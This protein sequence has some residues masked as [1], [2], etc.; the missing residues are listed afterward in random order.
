VEDYTEA[1]TR[2][3]LLSDYWQGL[4]I[5]GS[6]AQIARIRSSKIYWQRNLQARQL[7]IDRDN[8]MPALEGFR[9]AG[10]LSIDIDGNDYWVWEAIDFQPW[11]VICEY[12]SLFGPTAKISIPYNSKFQRVH[13][14][15]SNLYFGCSLNALCHLA[16]KKGYVFVGCNRMGSNAFFVR[17]D[18]SRDFRTL[19]AEEGFVLT[20]SR[21]SR[22]TEGKLDYLNALESMELIASLPVVDVENGTVLKLADLPLWLE[23]PDSA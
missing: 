18:V 9:E 15:Y 21:Q 13:A 2:Y 17:R 8:I 7:F 23:R 16:Q 1:N 19:S 22:N 5:D 14:H 3:L 6:E 4:I 10:L 20:P 11:I 12:N